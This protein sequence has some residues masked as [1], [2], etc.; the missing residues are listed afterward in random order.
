MDQIRIEN[1]E[2]FAY[3]GGSRQEKEQG[4][5]FYINAV[6]HLDLRLAGMTDRL[7]YTVDYGKLCGFIEKFMRSR[8]YRLIETAAER[9]AEEILLGFPNVKAVD[10]EIR[11]QS[12]QVELPFGSIGAF[13]H[14]KWHEAYLS[15]SSNYGDRQSYINQ[16]IVMLKEQKQCRVEQYSRIFISGPA[17]ESYSSGALKLYTLYTP[18]ELRDALSRIEERTGRIPNDRR[19]P[20]TLD[21]DILFY[22]DEIIQSRDLCIP[23]RDMENRE[24]VIGPL[25]QIAGYLRHPATG[26]TVRQMADEL[27]GKKG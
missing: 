1:L 21:L 10:I 16:G 8:T 9:L 7:K 20:R 3:H 14:R 19:A 12:A 4:Q 6:L 24:Y 27:S 17:E 11:K 26:K 2:V 25:A 23:H 5:T 13:I 18:L 22:D 15:F